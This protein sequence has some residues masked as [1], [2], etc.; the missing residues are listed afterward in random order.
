MPRCFVLPP[1]PPPRYTP[2]RSVHPKGGSVPPNRHLV[3][4]LL[5]LTTAPF[6]HAYESTAW[7]GAANNGLW[8]DP[9]NWSNGLP[10]AGPGQAD[11]SRASGVVDLGGVTRDS[12]FVL[13]S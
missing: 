1:T 8:A 4:L 3:A 11:V 13:L 6:A 10:T 7:T 5:S 12:D 9:L 2:P